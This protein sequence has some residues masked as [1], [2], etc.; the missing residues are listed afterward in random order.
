MPTMKPNPILILVALIAGGWLFVHMIGACIGILAVGLRCAPG[1]TVVAGFF[2][3]LGLA[4]HAL[5]TGMR[6]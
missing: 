2:L 4:I 3:A 1:F 6:K 5:T